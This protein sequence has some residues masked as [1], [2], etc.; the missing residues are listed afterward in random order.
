MCI[1]MD[2]PCSACANGFVSKSDEVAAVKGD[3]AG[4]CK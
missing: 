3:R 1:C 2:V 4:L